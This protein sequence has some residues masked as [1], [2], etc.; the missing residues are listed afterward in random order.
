MATASFHS[1]A[2][3]QAPGTGA[4]PGTFVPGTKVTVGKHRVIIER[5]LSEGGFA[6]VYLVRVPGE[7]ETAVLKRVACADKDQLANMRT[8]VETM[9]KLKGHHKIVT[10]IDSHASQLKGGGYEVF[11][12]M[13]FCAGGGL[14]DFMN[15]RLQHR[16]TEPEILKIFADVAEGV[17]CM[18]YLK[19]PLLHR[20]LKVEN[21]LI[22]TTPSRVYKLCDFGSTA[23]PRAAATNAA[24]GRLIEDDIQRH[25]TLQYRSPEMIDVYR[26]QPIDEKSDIW[27]LGVLLYKLCYYTTPFED[28][29]QMAILNATFKFPHYPPFSD[30]TKK[31]ISSMLRE[32]PALRPNI[33]QV[34]REVCTIRNAPCPIKDIYSNRS[35]SEA[36][37]YEELPPAESSMTSPPMV[38]IQKVAPAPVTTSSIP[39]IAPMRRGRPTAQNQQLPVTVSSKAT[40]AGSRGTSSDPF[41]ALDSKD[42]AVRTAAVDELASKFPSLDEFSLLHDR[43]AKFEFGQ[44]APATNSNPG[45]LNKRVTDALADEVFSQPVSKSN[46][47]SKPIAPIRQARPSSSQPTAAV[48]PP[49]VLLEPSPQKAMMVSTG[50]Q[51][52]PAPSPSPPKRFEANQRPPVWRVPSTALVDEP[53]VATSPRPPIIAFEGELPP[54]PEKTN[55]RPGILERHRTKSQNLIIPKAPVSS[56]PS[57][58]ASRPD[59]LDLSNP[60]SRSKSANARPRPSS[61]YVDSNI[62]YLRDRDGSRSKTSAP[63]P[64]RSD[65]MKSHPSAIDNSSDEEGP[66]DPDRIAS[67]VGFLRTMEAENEPKSMSIVGKMKSRRSSSGGKSHSHRKSM[68][69]ISLSGTKNIIAGRFGD[70]FR[71]FESNGTSSHSSASQPIMAPMSPIP[72]SPPSDDGRLMSRVLTPIAGSEA[73]GTSGGRSDDDYAIDETESLSP[74]VRRE[75]ERRRLSQEEKRVAAAGLEYRQRL[76]QGGPAPA[77][78]AAAIQNRVKSLLEGQKEV[79]VTRTAEGYGKFT[80]AARPPVPRTPN[81]IFNNKTA[82]RALPNP[83]VSNVTGYAPYSAPASLDPAAINRTGSRPNV[84]PK[85][86]GLRTGTPGPPSGAQ[87]GEDWE[88]NFSKK[89]PSLAGIEMVEADIRPAVRV[90][91][92]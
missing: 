19:P 56:R 11:L 60:T 41:A 89:Y 5:Y 24:E 58:E 64:P 53:D 73:T 72:M 10:Y 7:Q 92:V 77:S 40:P 17:A 81:A 63:L 37:R 65:Q 36:R 22:S 30:P 35:Q 31:L 12:L 52:S 18:H 14:I 33:Y 69:S 9:K 45:N 54:R 90:K 55:S 28:Q 38:G 79:Q 16:L 59:A 76:Q 78:K 83:A 42:V 39:D 74:E 13:E 80:D 87:D 34:V 29:G 70:A 48:R 50:I 20:D 86:K 1:P 75:L 25:T 43:G 46:A 2:G 21:V 4:P 66:E 61:V 67:N 85:P 23:P 57:L 27:A 62:N 68:P 49:P 3:F 91:D 82:G 84:A 6:H 8:E 47:V 32:N 88:A 15:T 26:K 44:A 51:T 71:R